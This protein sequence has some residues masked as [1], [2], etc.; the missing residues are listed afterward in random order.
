MKK[1]TIALL[2]IMLAAPTL[3]N[4]EKV[5]FDKGF[6]S[7]KRNIH[8]K[9]VPPEET[10]TTWN[11]YAKK[12]ITSG[13][14]SGQLENV[15]R[16]NAKEVVN[17]WGNGM[18]FVK[19]FFGHDNAEGTAVVNVDGS[20]RKQRIGI[21]SPYNYEGNYHVNFENGKFSAYQSRTS[22]TPMIVSIHK[23]SAP[24]KKNCN[25][26]QTQDQPSQC[27]RGHTCEP[28]VERSSCDNGAWGPWQVVTPPKCASRPSWC[29]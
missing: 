4:D 28:G 2:S 24:M 9:S 13:A 5:T 27:S 29:R 10:I 7:H 11:T 12:P 1:I 3:A 15:W 21:P 19:V 23:Q 22:G 6:E 26:G 14:G 20:S 8:N 17:S 18:Y 16:G 25:L